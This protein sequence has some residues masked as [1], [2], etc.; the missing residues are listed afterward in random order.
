MKRKLLALTM[1]LSVSLVLGACGE[2]DTSE[3]TLLSETPIVSESSASSTETVTSETD[4]ESVEDEDDETAG[5]TVVDGGANAEL[6]NAFIAG[7]E[8]AEIT[9]NGD[10]AS[11]YS[12]TGAMKAGESYT[13]NEMIENLSTYITEN[14]WEK[15]PTLGA[16]NHE[17]IDC[18][19]DGNPELHVQIELP[20]DDIE[21]FVI[22]MIVVAKNGHLVVA[23]D[24]DSWSRNTVTVDTTG[25]V[26]TGGA[27]GASSIVFETGFVNAAG[28]YVFGYKGKTVMQVFDGDYYFA[29]PTDLTSI[30]L[31]GLTMDGIMVEEISFEEKATVADTYIMLYDSYADGESSDP[32]VFEASHPVRQAFENA[33]FKIITADELT[34]L[35]NEKMAAKGYVGN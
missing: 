26:T 34:Q 25:T 14:G 16:I 32:S 18:G 5:E 35:T 4:T 24:G 15:A 22:E 6:F 7:T 10:R 17:F 28:D 9:E 29:V 19:K 30:D 13:I 8:K 27:D 12:F 23:Y 3:S 31:S 11:Y 1:L 33:G 21:P 20:V 2:K